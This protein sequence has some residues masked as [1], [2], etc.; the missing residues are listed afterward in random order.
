MGA[1]KKSFGLDAGLLQQRQPAL[2]FGSDEGRDPT[3]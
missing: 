3:R 1:V 2:A